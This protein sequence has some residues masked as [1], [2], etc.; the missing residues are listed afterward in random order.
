MSKNYAFYLL[1]IFANPTKAARTILKEQKLTKITLYSFLIGSLLYIIIVLI[2]YQALGW[3]SFPYRQYYP[4]YFSPYWWEVFV[5]PIW[6]LVIA[7]GF[8]IPAYF[9]GKLLGG[10]ATFKQVIAFIMLASIV[11]LPVFAIVDII[12]INIEPDWI[13]RFA[14]YGENIVPYSEHPN[15]FLWITQ[16]SYSYVAMTWQGVITIIGLSIIHKIRWY[17]NLPAMIIGNGIL[18]VFLILIKDYVA[19]II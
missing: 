4:Y 2:G 10:K 15:K 18:F 5:V 7:F 13:V 14:K 19:L 16:N 17:K 6:G 11:S 3:G 1:N 12:T 9:I 8:A